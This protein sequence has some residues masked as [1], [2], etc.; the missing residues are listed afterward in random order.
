[1]PELSL[2]ALVIA[3]LGIAVAA[4]LKAVEYNGLFNKADKE[5]ADLRAELAALKKQN[6]ETISSMTKLHN[7]EV[8]E[9]SRKLANAVSHDD[10]GPFDPPPV[11]DY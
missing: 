9:L 11:A 4:T 7:K 10:V 2:W 6:E 1:M 8:D 5:V 3:F